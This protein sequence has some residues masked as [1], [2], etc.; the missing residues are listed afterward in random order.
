MVPVTVVRRDRDGAAAFT[1]WVDD[2]IMDERARLKKKVSAPDPR[3]WNEQIYAV[4]VFDQLIHNFD[5][6]LGNLLIDREWRIWMIDHT[7]A[8]KTFREVRNPDNL[9]IRCARGLMARLRALDEPTLVSAVGDVL[10]REQIRGLLARR[11]V[12]V[13]HYQTRIDQFGEPAVLY[14]LPSRII[15]LAPR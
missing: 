4:R 3:T 1:W 11:D 2:V 15:E 6:N 14:D 7:R 12:I 13:Q 9:G 8:F 5:R 10:E